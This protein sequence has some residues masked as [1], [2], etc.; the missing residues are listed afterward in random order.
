MKDYYQILGV[1][2]TASAEEI[3]RVYRRLAVKY[4]PDKNPDP[5]AE[6][7]FKEINEAYDVLSDPEKKWRYDQRRENRVSQ[8]HL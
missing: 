1:N 3:K 7:I 6:A 4:H 2:R 8:L 5:E